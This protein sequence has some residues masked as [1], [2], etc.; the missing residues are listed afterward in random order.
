MEPGE[1]ITSIEEWLKLS[2]LT[3]PSLG[4]NKEPG[5][6][7]AVIKVGFLAVGEADCRKMRIYARR[8]LGDKCVLPTALVEQSGV[9]QLVRLSLDLAPWVIDCVA[10]ANAGQ[11]QFPSKVEFGALNGRAYAEFAL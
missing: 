8:V 11:N 10:L 6:I 5:L 2:E 7:V 4:S 3:V 9:R 1:Q